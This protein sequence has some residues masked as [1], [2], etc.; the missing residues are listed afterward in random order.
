MKIMSFNDFFHKYGLKN[1]TTPNIKIQNTL[2]S[3]DLNDE[4]T[5]SR[6]VLLS[7]DLGKIIS[8]PTKETHW[9]VYINETFFD[10]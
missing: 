2:F 6:D 9:V 7:S 3:L 5:Y 10:S 4:G 1:K 8:H